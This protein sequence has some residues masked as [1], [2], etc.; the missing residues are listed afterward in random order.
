MRRTAAAALLVLMTAVVPLVHA[1]Q[2]ITKVGV[3]DTSRIYSVYFQDS[4]ALRDLAAFRQ[5]ILEESKRLSDDITAVRAAKVDAER[6]GRKDEALR[7]ESQILE[8][9]NFLREYQ[10][11]KNLEFRSRQSKVELE[12]SFLGELADAIAYVAVSEGFSMIMEK[13]NPIFLYFTSESD[14]T[15]RV[16]QHLFEKAGK[17]YTPTN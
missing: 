5:S 15:E 13:A 11:V 6:D 16:L 12:S 10:R 8:K 1:Q 3:V 17:T 14:I 7:L 9:E 2:E 4:R